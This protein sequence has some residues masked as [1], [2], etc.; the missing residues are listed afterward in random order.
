MNGGW[1]H[2]SE[3]GMAANRD[4]KVG[5]IIDTAIVSGKWF[6]IP[7]NDAIPQVE[8]LESK[9]AAFAYLE[10]KLFELDN[11]EAQFNVVISHSSGRAT[12]R[13]AVEVAFSV[14]ADRNGGYVEVYKGDEEQAVF[15]GEILDPQQYPVKLEAL[16]KDLTHLDNVDVIETCNVVFTYGTIARTPSEAITIALDVIDHYNGGYVEAFAEGAAEPLIDCEIA[17]LTEQQYSP[18]I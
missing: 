18:A 1:N 5:G 15:E 7:N 13:E 2:V 3:D 9:E 17:V 12:L 14:V 16:A 8:D 11:P 6:V 4:P 10:Q